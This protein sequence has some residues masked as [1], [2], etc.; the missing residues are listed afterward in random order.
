MK[1]RMKRAAGILL[2]LM[3][4]VSLFPVMSAA[5]PEDPSLTPIGQVE[6]TNVNTALTPGVRPVFTAQ[7]GAG[8]DM[9]SVKEEVWTDEN[10]RFMISSLVTNDWVVI[11][12]HTYSYGITLEPKE[13]YVFD[14]NTKLIYN[15]KT[16]TQKEIGSVVKVNGSGL[17]LW[18]FQEDVDV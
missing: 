10:D 3:L 9:A 8:S 18:D 17:E 12:G 4:V 2:S 16:Y 5:E 1:N 6:V 14:E 7:I 13:G 11:A 15:G